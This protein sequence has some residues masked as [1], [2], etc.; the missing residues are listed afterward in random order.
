MKLIN[1]LIIALSAA[2]KIADAADE[3]NNKAA[4]ATNLLRGTFN[5]AFNSSM[6]SNTEGRVAAPCSSDGDCSD[7]TIVRSVPATQAINTSPQTTS[8]APSPGVGPSGWRR[9]PQYCTQP[10]GGC[11]LKYNR[12][13]YNQ[14]GGQCSP[15]CYCNFVNNRNRSRNG[16]QPAFMC[17]SNHMDDS[18]DVHG[19][20]DVELA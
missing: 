15:G 14:K 20:D 6:A 9:A 3:N 13:V 2:S 17:S 8:P 18:E 16:G 4:V 7:G 5:Y 12:K 19:E 10:E 11:V 1:L